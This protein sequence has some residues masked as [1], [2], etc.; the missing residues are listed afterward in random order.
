MSRIRIVP[1]FVVLAVA[2][3]VLFGG[4]EL[5]RNFGLVRPLEDTLLQDSAVK[6]VETIV[7]GSDREIKIEMK[8][9]ADLQV[10]YEAL[11]EKVYHSLGTKQVKIDLLDTRDEGLK[12]FYRDLQPTLYAGIAQGDFPTMIQRVRA[13]ADKAGVESNLSMNDRYIFVQLEKG[14]HY[15]YEV[16]PYKTVTVEQLMGVSSL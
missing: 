9:V 7:Q 10:T 11:E 16:L 4:W 2:L 1:V 6:R 12:T 14:D 3:S 13:V 8:P 5:Y 15:L